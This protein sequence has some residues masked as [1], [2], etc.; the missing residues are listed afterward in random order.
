MFPRF[1]AQDETL[2]KTFAA[3]AALDGQFL[4]L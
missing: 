3:Q 1:D 2:L 4:Q